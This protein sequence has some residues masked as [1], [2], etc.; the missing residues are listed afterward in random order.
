MKKITFIEC[1][2]DWT[3]R[4]TKKV[5]NYGIEILATS[6]SSFISQEDISYYDF[7][8]G[9][10]VEIQES[11]I[12]AF[13]VMQFNF[14]SS[15]KLALE[16][17]EKYPY[18]KIIFG[19]LYVQYYAKK[20]MEKYFFIDYVII[21]SIKTFQNL[22]KNILNKKFEVLSN[23]FYRK[24]NI[25]FQSDIK[26]DYTWKKIIPQ[27]LIC[28]NSFSHQKN[29]YLVLGS[30]GCKYNCN[31]CLLSK[32]E[33]YSQRD[34]KYILKEI[35]SRGINNS[36]QILDQNFCD[37]IGSLMSKLK[38]LKAISFNSRTD[39]FLENYQSI[40]EVLKNNPKTYFTIFVGI[41][42]YDDEELLRLGK[43]ITT[44]QNILA[45]QKLNELEKNF[46]NF[47]YKFS[48]IGINKKTKINN[49]IKNF[50]IVKKLF[51]EENIIKPVY[52]LY[53]SHL[54][55][56]NLR[57]FI[58]WPEDEKT[59][60]IVKNYENEISNLDDY[61]YRVKYCLDNFCDYDLI[62]KEIKI[63]EK[64]LVFH[65]SF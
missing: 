15:I 3:D 17:K 5:K 62:W 46:L 45:T 43:N 13:S 21:G 26:L 58:E 63:I 19:G 23:L 35:K 60:T 57:G 59:K 1:S 37:R 55:N 25:I 38:D 31:F 2:Y 61:F 9:E 40:L 39:T 33:K 56:N 41:E 16:L 4:I 47:S 27:K 11:K 24:N 10:N 44:K 49:L 20:I 32:V 52:T 50:E 34:E 28:D 22:V 29:H 36:F 6:I 14:F 54:R 53:T 64:N 8:I 42:N 12:Y 65:K 18:S 30:R 51:V 7:T 48:F